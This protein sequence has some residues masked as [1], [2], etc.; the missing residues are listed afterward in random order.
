MF[1]ITLE[2][3]GYAISDGDIRVAIK[4]F[5]YDSEL[6]KAWVAARTC[7]SSE[8]PDDLF[9]DKSKDV[10]KEEKERLVSEVLSAGHTSVLE[11]T[12]FTFFISGVSRVLSHQLVRHRLASYSQQSQRYVDIRKAD[13][14][15]SHGLGYVVPPR[16]LGNLTALEVYYDAM[17]HEMATYARLKSLGV[18]DEDA[19]FILGS[20]WKTNIVMTVNFTELAHICNE[21]MC[22]LAQWE[23]RKLVIMMAKLVRDRIPLVTP[24]LVPK[25]DKLG[26][27]PESSARSCGRKKQKQEFLLQSQHNGSNKEQENDDDAGTEKEDG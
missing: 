5:D 24:Y 13:D 1:K 7:Y 8:L 23:I 16:I 11:H 21:R 20:G 18:P 19:R 10:S 9:F 25:C 2:R 14:K 17:E 3:D 4:P 15:V 26:W 12:G 6:D 22:N 27:C